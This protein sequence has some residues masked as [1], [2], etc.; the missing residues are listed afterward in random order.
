MRDI[1]LFSTPLSSTLAAILIQFHH[2]RPPAIE[3]QVLAGGKS[4][5]HTILKHGR[6][7]YSNKAIMSYNISRTYYK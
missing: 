5:G 1:L 7:F 3:R 2:F 6:P 4:I